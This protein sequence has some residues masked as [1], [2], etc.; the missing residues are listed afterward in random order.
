[1]EDFE[2]QSENQKPGRG[3]VRPG[4]GRPKGSTNLITAATLLKAIEDRSGKPF[5]EHLADGY[6]NT[7]LNDDKKMRIEYE[8]MILGKVVAE[9]M[10]VEVSE[11]ED[12]IEAKQQ[13]F[14][15][16]LETLKNLPE[17]NAK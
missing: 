8:R 2:K 6:T 5:E 16:A 3:G 7:I 10:A 11:S 17:N 1:M 14:F 4:A 9:K 12:A 13:A 15:E